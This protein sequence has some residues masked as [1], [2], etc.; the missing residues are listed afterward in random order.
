MYKP[1]PETEKQDVWL[2]AYQASEQRVTQLE[3]EI[4]EVRKL[5]YALEYEK[6]KKGITSFIMK[7]R[8]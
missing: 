5:N 4:K 8:G 2:K 1:Q 3:N 7:D 6:Q